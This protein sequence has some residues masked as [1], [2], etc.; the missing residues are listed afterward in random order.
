MVLYDNDDVYSKTK[1]NTDVVMIK[2]KANKNTLICL[3]PIQ[4]P[5]Q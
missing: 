4:R 3:E 2:S 1:N 5:Q